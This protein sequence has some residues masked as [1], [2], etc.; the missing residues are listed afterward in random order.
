MAKSRWS[1]N[2]MPRNSAISVAIITAIKGME[3]AILAYLLLNLD[4]VRS[5]NDLPATIP[6]F[7]ERY[8]SSIA[9]ALAI[10]TTHSRSNP[11]REP[12]AMLLPKFPGS[13]YATLTMVAGPKSLSKRSSLTYDGNNLDYFNFLRLD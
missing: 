4:R 12:E 5:T 1:P 13:I 10:H 2:A 7:P 11:W 9:T 6:S 8:C 3:Y